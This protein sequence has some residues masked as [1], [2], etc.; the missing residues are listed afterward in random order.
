MFSFAH[1][2]SVEYSFWLKELCDMWT[3]N[4]QSDWFVEPVCECFD[5]DCT[6]WRFDWCE[7]DKSSVLDCSP[8]G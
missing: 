7:S 2:W 4:S 3:N 5:D 6:F 8:C 1:V